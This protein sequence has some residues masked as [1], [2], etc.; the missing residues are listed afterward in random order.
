MPSRTSTTTWLGRDQP[1]GIS[2]GFLV[3]RVMS[4]L[5]VDVNRGCWEEDPM[6]LC[7]WTLGR[8]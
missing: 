1:G 3:E 2:K 5:S 6:A 7:V 8:Q 4:E